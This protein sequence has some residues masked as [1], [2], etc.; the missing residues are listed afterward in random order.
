MDI[1]TIRDESLAWS[2][3]MTLGEGS[4]NNDFAFFSCAWSLLNAGLAA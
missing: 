1:N 2:D 4:G 3:Y